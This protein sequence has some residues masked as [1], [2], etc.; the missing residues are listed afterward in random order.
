M[1][2]TKEGIPRGYVFVITL[3]L[4]GIATGCTKYSEYPNSKEGVWYPNGCVT[5]LG[6]EDGLLLMPITPTICQPIRITALGTM[7]YNTLDPNS[8]AEV[9]RLEFSNGG[10]YFMTDKLYAF[11]RVEYS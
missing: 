8:S 5:M 10:A 11:G 4:V 9:A 7:T 3:L 6:R 1:A 2:K